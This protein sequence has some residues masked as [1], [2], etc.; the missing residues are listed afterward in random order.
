MHAPLTTKGPVANALQAAEFKAP[1]VE[2][3]P[4]LWQEAAAASSNM[5]IMRVVD[6][7]TALL[8]ATASS[9]GL[10]DVVLPIVT[11]GSDLSTAESTYLLDSTLE[12]W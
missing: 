8:T 5:T 12:L 10:D 7:V 4:Q 3:I 1:L 9:D 2:Y 11:L 6:L